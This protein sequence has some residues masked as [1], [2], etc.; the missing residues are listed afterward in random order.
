MPD[1]PEPE[2]DDQEDSG[3]DMTPYYDS[4]CVAHWPGVGPQL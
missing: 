4:N 1:N 2:T 3:E